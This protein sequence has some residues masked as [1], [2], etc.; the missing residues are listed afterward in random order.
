[1][2]EIPL[3][4]WNAESQLAIGHDWPPRSEEEVQRI[5][6]Q[7][8]IDGLVPLFITR[9]PQCELVDAFRARGRAT[10]RVFEHRVRRFEAAAAH[11][12]RVLEGERFLF[13]KGSDYAYRFYDDPVLRPLRDIDI[14][15]PRERLSAVESRLRAAGFPNQ[16]L[17]GVIGRTRA[18]HETGYVIDEDIL[19]EVHHSFVQ[20]SRYAVDYDAI[21]RD[22]VPFETKAY[23]GWRLSDLHTL[24]YQI[25]TMG[26]EDLATILIRYVDLMLMLDRHRELLP[27]LV[28]LAPRW[29]IARALY[30]ALKMITVIIPELDTAELRAIM[31][32]T[33]PQRSR[34]FIDAR[35]LPN[36]FRERGNFHDRGR[37]IQLWRKLWLL[38]N[39]RRRSLFF[40]EHAWQTARGYIAPLAK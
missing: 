35:V 7:A 23:R 30:A 6:D 18:Y 8:V 2:I 31:A 10:M 19:L 15:V 12:A 5:A 38:D 1:V 9:A 20:R 29:Q 26:K 27:E 14:L 33:L 28:A 16:P 32:A 36:P 4:L 22:A 37:F 17:A 3:S 24:A 39:W 21:W 40:A 13:L 25:I 11:V 34:D